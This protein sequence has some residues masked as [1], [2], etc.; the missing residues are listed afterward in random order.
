MSTGRVIDCKRSFF[1][2][3]RRRDG[4]HGKT[5]REQQGVTILLHLGV[6]EGAKEFRL[7]ACAYNE[8]TFRI[9]DQQ[10]YRPRNISIIEAEEYQKCLRTSLDVNRLAQEMSHRFPY[11]STMISTD[12]GRYVCNYVYC[13]SLQKFGKAEDGSICSLFLHVPPFSAVPEVE[14]LFYVSGLLEKLA[15]M[16]QAQ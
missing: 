14:Q 1:K 3:G 9:P 11:I 15:D 16:V 6:A 13:C 4:S 10:G 2:G 5:A 12:P 8:A 7:E